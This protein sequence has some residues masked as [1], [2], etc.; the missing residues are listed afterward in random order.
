VVMGLTLIGEACRG[1]G[2]PEPAIGILRLGSGNAIADSTGAGDDIVEDRLRRLTGAEA[3]TVVNNNAAAVMLVLIG[4]ASY[5]TAVFM[6]SADVDMSF[7]SFNG[8]I[9]YLGERWPGAR[10]GDEIVAVGGV[11]VAGRAAAR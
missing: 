4:A 2:R 11:G 3:A 1:A 6:A 9:K 7:S 10:L 8:Q 5:G